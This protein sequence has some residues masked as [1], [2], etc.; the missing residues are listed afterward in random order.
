MNVFTLKRLTY[1]QVAE[2]RFIISYLRKYNGNTNQVLWGPTEGKTHFWEETRKDFKK[3]NLSSCFCNI[4]GPHQYD[5][6]S[7]HLLNKIR[8]H[9]LTCLSPI[10]RWACIFPLRNLRLE[11]HDIALETQFPL[12]DVS[13]TCSLIP[14]LQIILDWE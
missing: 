12:V 14:Q 7:S 2:H 3:V 10:A 4:C 1:W 13:K 8:P 11:L 6:L 9:F 5:L